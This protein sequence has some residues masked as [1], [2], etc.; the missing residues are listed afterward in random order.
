MLIADKES[1]LLVEMSQVCPGETRAVGWGLSP[2]P[3]RRDIAPAGATT[4][5]LS[6]CPFTSCV[7]QASLQAAVS[8]TS[9]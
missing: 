8:V 3:R 4:A 2:H 6:K 5:E 7:G 9:R 1:G